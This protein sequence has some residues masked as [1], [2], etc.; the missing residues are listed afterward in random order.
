MSLE[1]SGELHRVADVDGFDAIPGNGMSEARF[2]FLEGTVDLGSVWSGDGGS[3]GDVLVAYARIVDAT[4]TDGDDFDAAVFCARYDL[5]D[6]AEVVEVSRG[7]DENRRL[8][9][10]TNDDFSLDD[11]SAEL[12]GVATVPNDAEFED[13]A[14][15]APAAAYVYVLDARSSN[16]TGLTGL[17]TR[18]Y[19][20]EARRRTVGAPAGLGEAF[21]PSAASS[22][23]ALPLRVDNPQGGEV[24]RVQV[25]QRQRSVLLSFVQGE[26]VW[27]QVTRD[28]LRYRETAGAPNPG[29]VDNDTSEDVQDYDL[30]FCVDE[31]GDAEG[32][33]FWFS[34]LDSVGRR[35]LR[36]R[37]AVQVQPQ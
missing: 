14:S 12:V 8:S 9:V 35:R 7:V 5:R 34:K 3:E 25:S 36:L 30:T 13:E 10:A 20:M 18:R 28:G 16:G 6:V 26:H 33:L 4:T 24:D 22:G 1:A 21:A 11:F 2:R 27:I 15:S 23:F 37:G 32:G 19:D 17:F 29:L 31:H